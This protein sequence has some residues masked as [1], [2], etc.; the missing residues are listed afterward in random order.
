[1][2]VVY[3]AKGTS[4]PYFTIGKK[5]T[6][7][8]QGNTD[9]SSSYTISDGDLWVDT[10]T[11]SIKVR[12]SSSWDVPKMGNFTIAG[13]T[14]SS[15]ELL[16][17]VSASASAA[18]G[19]NDADPG[20]DVV[21]SA[22]D[23]GGSV[24]GIA[25]DG[26]NLVFNIGDHGSASGTGSDGT[27]GD[28]VVKT[29]DGTTLLTM[30]SLGAVFNVDVSAT[31]LINTS[32]K[33]YKKDIVTFD[34]ISRFSEIRPVFYRRKDNN[35]EEIGFIAE[36]MFEQYPELV[37]FNKEGDIDGI[38]YGKMSAILTAK[39]QDQDNTIEAQRGEID[40]LK[41]RLGAIEEALSKISKTS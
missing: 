18:T 6:T 31:D 22:G 39:V 37:H 17:L 41:A 1:M 34:D 24:D 28:F 10:S 11:K 38:D 8:Y 12:N 15:T 30:N 36:E 27:E 29:G 32:S 13:N 9:P 23:G 40:E 5:G 25:G 26:G 4:I 35:R 33:R 16:E 2:A 7:I 20:S 14:I 3:N 19:T 21:I